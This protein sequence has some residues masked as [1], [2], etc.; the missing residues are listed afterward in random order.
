MKYRMKLWRQTLALFLSLLLLLQA[1]PFY[2]LNASASADEDGDFKAWGE[3]VPKANRMDVNWEPPDDGN[4]YG[5][6]Y[7]QRK[8]DPSLPE[9]MQEQFETRS[10]K[11]NKPVNVLVIYPG[12][13]GFYN[14]GN[15]SYIKYWLQGTSGVGDIDSLLRITDVSQANF[16][17]NPDAYLKN[18]EGKYVIDVVIIGVADLNGSVNTSEAAVNAIEDF[19]KTGRGVLFGH[20]TLIDRS[21]SNVGTGLENITSSTANRGEGW[22][23]TKLRHYAG[24]IANSAVARLAHQTNRALVVRDG[25]LLKY[26][27]VIKPGDILSVNNTHV[28]GSSAKGTIWLQFA[29]ANGTLYQGDDTVGYDDGTGYALYHSNYYLTTYHNTA[30]I[31]TGHTTNANIPVA[32]R[33]IIANTVFFLAQLTHDT[34]LN[35]NAATDEA[36]PDAP[37]ASYHS[38]NGTAQ[39]KTLITAKDNGTT[40]QGYVEAIDQNPNITERKKSNIF[41]EMVTSGTK[42]Y[43]I[44]KSENA[45]DDPL[46]YAEMDENDNPVVPAQYLHNDDIDGLLFTLNNSDTGYIH[47]RAV[48]WAGNVGPVSHNNIGDLMPSFTVNIIGKVQGKTEPQEPLYTIPLQMRANDE[49]FRFPALTVPGYKLTGPESGFIEINPA[50]AEQEQPFVFWYTDNMTTV[51]I[52]AMYEGTATPI[53]SFSEYRVAAEIGK[54]FSH[55]PPVIRG[56]DYEGAANNSTTPDGNSIASVAANG[57]HEIIFYYTKQT[58]EKGLIINIVDI[59][60]IPLGTV[61]RSLVKGVPQDMT[62]PNDPKSVEG[63]EVLKHYTYKSV[64]PDTVTYDGVNDINV[65]YVYERIKRTVKAAA[66]DE[67]TGAKITDIRSEDLTVGDTHQI[68]AP[69]S[70]THNGVDYSIIG[71]TTQDIYVSNGA[72]AV[73]IKFYYKAATEGTVHVVAWYDTNGSGIYEPGIDQVIQS[74]DLSGTVGSSVSIPAPT[75]H[76]WQL[77]GGEAES[78][79]ATVSA[80]AQ[81]IYFQYNKDV[82]TVEVQLM[83]YLS[84]AEITTLGSISYEVPKGDSLTVYAPNVPDYILT[85]GAV[86]TNPITYPIVDENKTATFYYTPL[87]DAIDAAYVDVTIKGVGN[88]LTLYSYTK[89]ILKGTEPITLRDEADV[90][91]I[92]GYVLDAGQNHVFTPDGSV[93]EMIFTYT[94]TAATVTINMVDGSGN[95]VAPSFNVA[96]T[97]GESFSYTAPSVSGY[98]LEGALTQSISSVSSVNNS[99][100]FVYSQASGNVMVVLTEG[101]RIIK[102]VSETF[103]VNE[104]REIPVPDLAA[105]YYT[106]LS[107]ADTVT[108]RGTALTV[109]YQYT[110]DLV[111]IPVQAV[112]YLTNDVLDT[113]TLANQR[114]GESLTVGAPNVAD[115]VL[116]GSHTQTAIADGSEV[117]FKYRTLA[118]DEVAV[119]AVSQDGV[120]LQS[121]VMSGTV[122]E[123]VSAMAPG[124]L[125]WRL[126]TGAIQQALVGTDKEIGF[127]YEADVVT[128]TVKSI[129]EQ[130]APIGEAAFQTARGGSFE[131]HAPHVPGYV[132]DDEKTKE[133]TYVVSDTSVTF[134]YKSIEDV[135]PDYT[136]AIT[137]IGK[138]ATEELYEY[139]ITRPKNSGALEVDAFQV[140]GYKLINS[141]PVSV[142]VGDK[143]ETVTFDYETLA[144]VVAIRMVDGSGNEVAP[145]FNVAAT[146]GDS[147]S[148]SAPYVSG[149]NLEGAITQTISSVSSAD[150][151]LTFEYS[152]ASG[153]VTVVLKE[154]S[155]IIKTLSE[156]FAVNETREIPVPDLAADHYTARSTADT[157][158][159]RGTALTVEYQYAKDL[160]DIPVKAVDYVTSEV[161]D[162]VTKANQRKGEA[163][164]IGAPNV[165]DH[166]LVGS[167]TQTAIADGSEVIFHYKTVANDEVAVKVVSEDGVLLQSYMMSGTIGETVYATAPSILGWRL[168]SGANQQ[169][170]IGSDKEIV[171]TYAADVVTVTVRAINEQGVSIGEES[172][173]TARGGSFKAYAP[174]V[175][176]YVLDDESAKELIDIGADTSVTFRYKSIED[177]VPDYTVTITVIGKSGTEDLYKYGITRPKNSGAFEVDAFEV[178]GY[179]LINSSPVSVVVGDKDETVTF[180]YD[181]LATV[182][183]IRMV[184]VSGNEVAPSFN[185]AATTGESFSYNAPYVSGYN[186]EG[187]ITQTI[188]SVSSVSNSLTFVYSQAS[189]NVTVVLTEGGRI[190]KTASE[191]F[192][193][194]ETR[195]IPVPDLAADHY[196]AISTADTI[197]YNGTALTVEY[198]YTKDLVDIPVQAVDYVTNDVLDTVIIA[199]Q[200]KGEA[201]TV[202]APNVANYVLVGSQTQ[203]VIAD[204]SEV[205]FKYRT[206]ANDEVAVKAVAEDGVLLQGYIMSGTI[207]ET[208]YATAPSILGWRLTTGANQQALI[209]TDKEIVFTYAADVVTI[210]VKAVDEQGASISE[211]TFRT[212]R[213]GSFKAYAPHVSGYVLDDESIKELSDVAA[214][215]SVTFRYKK[216]NIET[217]RVTVHYVEQESKDKLRD[218]STYIGKEGEVLWLRADQITVTDVVYTPLRYNELYT[219]TTDPAQEYTFE[220]IEGEDADIQ[221][222][223]I[224]HLEAGTNHVLNESELVTGRS[225]EEIR[226][227]AT[228]ITVSGVTYKPEMPDYSYIFDERQDQALTIFYNKDV[229]ET[230]RQVLVKYVEQGTGLELAA[231][232]TMSGKPGDTVALTPVYVSE[233]TPVTSS[234]MYTFSEQER[235]EYTFYYTKNS[236]NSGNTDSGNTDTS[237]SPVTPPHPAPEEPIEPETDASQAG[238][239][240]PKLEMEHHY[241]YITGYP[242][243]TIRPENRISREEVAAIF[244]RL[245]EDESREHYISDKNSFSDVTGSRWSN[246]QISTL[247]DAGMITGYPDGT[248]KPGNFITRAEFAAI[249][250]RFDQLNDQANDMFSD[251]FGHWAEKYIVSAAN[252][253]WI[254]GYPDGTFKPNQ[255]ITRAEAM[256]FI[257]GM[258]NRKVKANDIHEHA[259]QWPDNKPGKWYYTHVLEATNYHDYSRNEDGYE[260]W[261]AVHPDRIH[262]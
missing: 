68:H 56:F 89:R 245:M 178:K 33:N 9:D 59:D 170:L 140:R 129:D 221:L 219:I 230:V 103:A 137:V 172:F 96:A 151:S 199:S 101:G 119:K 224:N 24:I 252:K 2:A 76:G 7:Y 194:N 124:I 11:Y 16:D 100:T 125:G 14:A 192:A 213:G 15:Q 206:L 104:T 41:E 40:Y 198:Q 75:I 130:G 207:G 262:P 175:S 227:L 108:Y 181:T 5:Y 36:P 43:L 234:H 239:E 186:L 215:A 118:N 259:K 153:N 212:A 71:E 251:V 31:Q 174:H 107:K 169:A 65:T 217:Y 77:A 95:E 115:H 147:F 10:T 200:R 22:Q 88:G 86:N 102:T 231:P 110:K 72:A 205:I 201:V 204:G 61:Y 202:G 66:Y 184:D 197:T 233:Y 226:Y 35:D 81:T 241:N 146:M 244:Y 111:D 97:T 159:Y 62:Y 235:Q 173:Q 112:D 74:Y 238:T 78:V 27:N 79:T 98:N 254:K 249:A 109:E 179:S 93:A 260:V 218:S 183:A 187:A 84:G 255:Y 63:L 53:E 237:P 188:S 51:T 99:L 222:L 46:T 120:S 8:F 243:G 145:S 228:P 45:D 225:G 168:T 6:L 122:G 171:F 253:G 220:Y 21:N 190:I 70:L 121:Y 210:T 29:N 223:T 82:W 52:K 20:D 38:A 250:S 67:A 156:T 189:G 246:K 166:V 142:T 248:F 203:T 117:I 47:V 158:T 23:Y 157:V 180:D 18:S 242:D 39:Y 50:T 138:S 134:R 211:E 141:S 87:E 64:E 12:S 17:A 247:E 83:D 113:V 191:T 92:P 176:G 144:T 106:A 136:V 143:D 127:T 167:Q 196:T 131:A 182:V 236:S 162:T 154:G 133:L 69:P 148:Y 195:E 105:D 28:N 32:E 240:T 60:N 177:V 85:T 54:P 44:H 232:M 257:N 261:Q 135:V 164:T 208:V 126:T 152:Q 150:S 165:A 3:N 114:K 149:Y 34:K 4:D 160:V 80:D 256:A 193:V 258:L 161:L 123:T 25:F 42:G 48:D 55:D 209:G 30:F 116:V 214:D 1:V 58:T 155:R 90:F 37:V 139:D 185:V 57:E 163:L 26:P 91:S 128:I 49:P 13:S 229:S 94:S 19:I 216:I 73:E 132:L